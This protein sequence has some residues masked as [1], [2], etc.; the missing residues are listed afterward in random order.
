MLQSM[1][2]SR[3]DYR[4][5]SVACM[6]IGVLGVWVSALAVPVTANAVGGANLLVACA[7]SQF[8][9]TLLG[10]W[11]GIDYLFLVS[12]LCCSLI[13]AFPGPG[14][15]LF[16]LSY[17]ALFRRYLDCVW[18]PVRAARLEFCGQVVAALLFVPVSATVATGDDW[19]HVLCAGSVLAGGVSV[20]VRGDVRDF[21]DVQAPV[22]I[23]YAY[24]L[25]CAGISAF[26]LGGILTIADS[27]TGWSKSQSTVFATA[28]LLVGALVAAVVSGYEWATPVVRFKIGCYACSATAMSAIWARDIHGYFLMSGCFGFGAAMTLIHARAVCFNN[29]NVFFILCQ[30]LSDCVPP[31]LMAIGATPR[32][33]MQSAPAFI[34]LGLIMLPSRIEEY[35]IPAPQIR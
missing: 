12:A 28:T 15:V 8:I 16:S 32:E 10:K 1:N 22:R 9:G 34:S 24:G 30:K 27:T 17:G 3:F 4:V 18:A 13:V 35:P 33:L 23:L 2:S 31:L 20:F 7:V 19:V 5:G 11:V 14:V 21:Q 6:C 25:V 26:S 29:S